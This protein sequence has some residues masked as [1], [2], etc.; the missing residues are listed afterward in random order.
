MIDHLKH[1]LEIPEEEFIDVQFQ[2]KNA[3]LLNLLEKRADKKY[4]EKQVNQIKNEL[5][6][7]ISG[8]T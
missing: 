7:S 8:S 3:K 1:K 5:N 4:C 6:Q 2:F